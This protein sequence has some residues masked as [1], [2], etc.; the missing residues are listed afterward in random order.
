[1]RITLSAE[2]KELLLSTVRVWD[3]RSLSQDVFRG[4]Q[5]KYGVPAYLAESLFWHLEILDRLRPLQEFLVFKGGTCVQ[6][7]LS[8]MLQRAS[9]DLDFNSTVENRN[10]IEG[11]VD[12]LNRRLFSDGRSVVIRGV[13]FGRFELESEDRRTGTLNFR[14]R[15]PSRFGEVERVGKDDIGA[16]PIRVQINLKHA[17]LPAIKTVRRPVSFFVCEEVRP[18][19]RVLFPHASVEDL[20][21]DKVLATRQRSGRERFKDVYDL[22]VLLG[23][24]PDP[25]IILEKLRRVAETAGGTAGEYL[26]SSATTVA[27]FGERSAEA[28]GFA[29]MAC[30]GGKELV[31]EWE[32]RCLETA[33]ELREMGNPPHPKKK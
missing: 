33:R 31:A 11:S 2:E 5:A 15:M 10:A 32:M 9:N 14:H 30:R 28:R 19:H 24:R 13:P 26:G 20:V 21:A 4:L 16:K 8:P 6:S 29:A 27:A 23:L 7:Y 3:R 1:M 22:M 25:A 17:W 12:E 18:K